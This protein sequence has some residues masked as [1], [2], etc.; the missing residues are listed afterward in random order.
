MIRSAVTLLSIAALA[1]P[2]F[3]DHLPIGAKPP[4]A[5]V[6]MDAH[7]GALVTLAKAKGKL[8]T[9]VIFTCNHCPWAKAWET[10]IA[11]IGN[12]AQKQGFGVVAINPNDAKKVP[13]DNMDAM[14]VRAKELKLEFPYAVDAT[15]G[16]AKA[17][18]A[19]KTPEVFLFDA[20]DKLV[21]YGAI[22][23]N[24]E[25]P[26]EVKHKFLEEALAAVA[27]KKPVPTAET[28]AIGCGI[29]WRDA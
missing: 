25:K 13:E 2:A 1:T 17:F 6:S 12:A 10:R 19:T 4:Q 20:N 22:D 3:A 18:G 23:D 14:K 27:A 7:T 5:D 16:I 26:A 21:Y 29:K 24:A 9:L 11:A 8:G 28:K 15:S